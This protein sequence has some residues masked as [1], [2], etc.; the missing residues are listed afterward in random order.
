MKRLQKHG[1]Q[2]WRSKFARSVA[3]V[4]SGTAAAQIITIAFSPIITRLYGPEAFGIL[5]TYM[6][7]LTILTPIAALSYPIAIVLPKHDVDAKGLV[8]LSLKLSVFTSGIVAVVLL[9]AQEQLLELL[10][11]GAVGKFI[12]FVPLAMLLSVWLAVATQWAVRKKLFKLKAKVSVINAL[13][14]NGLKSGIGLFAPFAWVLITITTLGSAVNAALYYFGIRKEPTQK[15]PDGEEQLTQK[16][17]AKQHGDFAYFRTPQIMLNAASQS[18][19]VLMLTA[20][21]GPSAAGFYTLGK[22]VLGAPT[23]LLGQSVHTVF[24][25]HFNEAILAGRSG[26]RLLIKSTVSLM[27]VGIWPFLVVIVAGPWLFEFVFGAEWRIA[28]ELARWLSLW[29]FV[30]LAARPAIA[31]IPVLNIQ[32]SFLIFEIFAGVFRF[33]SLYLSY[34][35]I[36]SLYAAVIWFTFV[37]VLI[38]SILILWVGFCSRQNIKIDR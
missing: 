11:I 6:A 19:P 29:L 32:G 21:F 27:V 25:P 26:L 3:I 36:G 33:L 15:L 1:L 35:M 8:K 34:K 7:L 10:N 16:Q 30:S 24:Y 23:Q 22:M 18:M 5:G 12:W 14:Q 2:L 37:N 17:L 28:G 38:Y 31:V 9:I 20:L 13:L 4:A